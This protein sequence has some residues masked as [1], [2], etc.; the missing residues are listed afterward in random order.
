RRDAARP[1]RPRARRRRPRRTMAA[2][3]GHRRRRRR[4][5]ASRPARRVAV[6]ERRRRAAAHADG[7]SR[8]GTL[9]LTE[10]TMDLGLEGR[11]AIVCASSRGLGKACALAL[12]REGV[13]VVVNGRNAEVLTSTAATIRGETGVQVTAVAADLCTE[14]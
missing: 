7:R 8:L 12:A 13:A 9:A 10:H 5:G 2:A 6:A 4:A 3:V 11:K 14:D 1:R